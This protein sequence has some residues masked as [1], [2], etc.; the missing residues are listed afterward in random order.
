M[1]LTAPSDPQIRP[2]GKAFAYVYKGE[3]RTATLPAA[4]A[5]KPAFKGVRPRWSP[6]GTR[7]AFL[8]NDPT[9]KTQ[10]FVRD[11]VSAIPRQVTFAPTSVSSFSWFPDG[12]AL[13]YIAVDGGK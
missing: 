8:T 12:K 1:Q 5:L 10:V 11:T 13:A 6:D 9:G 7:L 3:V 4:T 2:D